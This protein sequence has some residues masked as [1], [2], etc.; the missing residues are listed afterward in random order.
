MDNDD[1]FFTALF[2]LGILCDQ[3]RATEIATR[4]PSGRLPDG[5]RIALIDEAT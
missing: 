1:C 3:T 5:R 2:Q 4:Y